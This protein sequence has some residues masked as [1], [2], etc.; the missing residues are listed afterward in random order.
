LGEVHG[1]RIKFMGFVWSKLILRWPSLLVF[2]QVEY[3]FLFKV[4]NP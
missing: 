1:L 4:T 2:S 3:L